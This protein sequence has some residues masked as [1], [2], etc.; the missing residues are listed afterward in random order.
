MKRLMTAGAGILLGFAILW[1]PHAHAQAQTA[2]AGAEGKA[3]VL[4]PAEKAEGWRLLFDGKTLN[5]WRGYQR[6][7][8]PEA[9]RVQ[10]ECLMVPSSDGRD[11]KG[12]RDLI[13]KEQFD[14]FDLQFEWR[15]SHAGNSGVKYFV[16]EDRDAAIGHEYQVLDDDHHPDA[17]VSDTRKTA[18]FYD[19]LTATDKQLKPV[20]EFN[21]S[22]ILV[23]GNHVEHWLNGRKVLEY[24]LGSQ[25]T[26][27]AVDKSKFQ[28]MEGFGKKKRGHILLQDHGD[29]VCY[30]NIRIRAP[31]I[32]SSSQ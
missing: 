3:N 25:E 23:K 14:D 21:H 24:E 4:T 2:A 16:T 7:D 11:T 9:W 13:T 30:R 1:T 20:G 19:V 17:K 5:G 15:I 18:S 28:G 12:Q 8:P 22:R 27:A 32:A 10:G 6:E 26:L 31:D 29:E